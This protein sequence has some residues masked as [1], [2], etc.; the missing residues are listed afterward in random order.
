M[1]TFRDEAHPD[2]EELLPTS[3]TTKMSLLSEPEARLVLSS[4]PSKVTELSS[5][6]LRGRIQRARR[7]MKKYEDLARIQRREALRKRVPTRSRRAEGNANTVRKARY[8]QQ[9]LTRFEKRLA[10]LERL[11]ARALTRPPRKAMGARRTRAATPA[12]KTPRASGGRKPVRRV[13]AAGRTA[14]ASVR[15]TRTQRRKGGARKQQG[16]SAVRRNA[17][18]VARNRRTQARKDQRR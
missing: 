16:F 6:E 17:H 11:A 2:W 15:E 7:L 1:R 4:T 13:R 14:T 12:R 18:A 8:F 3:P 9:A 5:R 10:Q